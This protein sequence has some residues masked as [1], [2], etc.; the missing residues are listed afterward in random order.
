MYR[1]PTGTVSVSLPP[2]WAFDPLS[3]TLTDL[4]FLKWERPDERQIFV[5]VFP[6]HT[7]AGASDDEWEA[8]VRARLPQEATRVERVDGPVVLVERPGREAR[9]HQ[10]WALCRGP[11]FDAIV[12]DV[13]VPLGGA[14]VTAELAEALR[15][16]E[17]TANQSLGEPHEFSEFQAAM[18]SAY[19][20]FQ[21]GD[22]SGAVR[23]LSLARELASETWLHS[24]VA[25]ELQEIPAAVGAAE[26]MLALA[27]VAASAVFLQQGTLTLH[28]CAQSLARS[29]APSAAVHRKKVDRLMDDAVQMHGEMTGEPPPR[30][31]FS[32]CLMRSRALM[33]EL[34]EMMQG[35]HSRFGGPWAALALEEAMTAV[36]YAGRGILRAVPDDA[37][38]MFVEK[39]V[40]D[41]DEQL[42]AANYIFVV[43]AL[44]HL[45]AACGSVAAARAEAS[46]DGERTVSANWVLAARGLT[47]LSP[48]PER[49]RG[50]V[51]AINGHAGAFMSLGDEASLDEA[52]ALL[53]EAETILD[54]LKDDGSELRGQICLNQA[55]LRHYQ[56]RLDGSIAL[57]DRAIVCAQRSQSERL[58][59]AARS[60]R[61]QFLAVE[62]RHQEAVAEARRA[63]EGATDALS[64]NHLN[65]AIALRSS[66]DSDAALEEVRAGL[67]AA[68]ADDPLGAAA[69]RLLFVAA[70]IMESD[71]P[72]AS[73][74][75]TEAA[76]AV[77]DVL[78]RRLGD[79]AD[80]IGFDDAER[81][82]EIAANLVRR[83]LDADDILGALATADRHRARSL[84]RALESFHSSVRPS[85]AED[86]VPPTS[87]SSLYEHVAYIA[88]TASNAL[89]RLGVPQPLGGAALVDLVVEA[90]RPAVLFHPS[91]DDLLVFVVRPGPQVLVASVRA[92]VP[93]SHIVALTESLRAQLGIVVSARSARGEAPSQAIEDLRMLLADDDAIEDADVELANLQ[94]ELY[95]ALFS[96]VLPL[97]PEGKP[98]IVVPYRELGVIPLPVLTAADGRSLVERHPVSV[99]P[100]LASLRVI[101]RAGGT[102]ARAV[103]VGDPVVDQGLNL[104][105]LPG[106]AAEARHVAERLRA[107]GVETS[108]LL[109]GAATEAAFRTAARG[110]RIIHLACHATVRQQASASPLFFT[111]SPPEDGLLLPAE[112]ADLRLDGALVVL[113]ACQSGLGRATADGVLGLGRAFVQAGACAVVLSLWRVSDA[114]TA[115]LMAAF[116]D[117][118]L[119]IEQHADARLDV[120]AAIR[121]AQLE[122][123]QRVSSDPSAWGPWLVLGDGGWRLH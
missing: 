73:L 72:G 60:L 110:A 112:I 77:L 40:T 17:I 42:E 2:G 47:E 64:T 86:P 75:A 100:S 19:D 116:Y 91:G 115:L 34:Q 35:A 61:S 117:A 78:R 21:A 123:Q 92:A 23:G 5:R 7:S 118:L 22:R 58:E 3:S 28:R 55:W 69:L 16:I 50:L 90:D 9:P 30:N 104:G 121:H 37:V 27:R 94:H 89:S 108:L 31:P 98:V 76:E 51:L 12:E 11:R 119:G 83:R 54:R 84:A 107:A 105:P 18:Q 67:A 80:R 65:L 24:L 122:T 26:T 32:A 59:R 81:H 41:P 106:A 45:V 10:R 111:P 29:R 4:A 14:L 44:D 36:A 43:T 66:G 52:E 46:L 57:V 38:E 74:A 63:V 1:D 25:R 39:G 109:H 95:S 85:P 120:A 103:V 114:A 87:G 70:A 15:T 48:S 56:R 79:A 71:N 62:G 49:D 101:T 68:M 97:L 96:K 8:E 93:F 88:R 102:P 13:G 53:A 82:R 113:A 33:K 20:L 99:V 6:S